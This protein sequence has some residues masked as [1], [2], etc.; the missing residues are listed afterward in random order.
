VK[1]DSICLQ[2][3]YDRRFVLLCDKNYNPIS[4]ENADQKKTRNK[5]FY[6]RFPDGFIGVYS[7]LEGPV[8]FVN[9]DKK[10]FND[11]TWSVSVKKRAEVNE[12]SFGGLSNEALVFEYPVVELD[13]LNPWSEEPFDDFFIWLTSKR[14]DREFIEIWT[15]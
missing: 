1:V 14:D 4:E 7:S 11:P 2:H 9:D 8:L 13:L 10:L 3:K 15:D 6:V 12:V 5:A